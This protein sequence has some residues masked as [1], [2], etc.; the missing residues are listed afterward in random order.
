MGVLILQDKYSTDVLAKL[1]TQ[2]YFDAAIA[3]SR[4][5][6]SRRVNDDGDLLRTKAGRWSDV[7][8]NK[9]GRSTAGRDRLRHMKCRREAGFGDSGRVGLVCGQAIVFRLQ[10]FARF[11]PFRIERDARNRAHLLAL[12]LSEMTDAFRAFV[13][14]DLVELRAHRD[15]VVRA[16]GLAHVAI[17][18]VVG[19]Q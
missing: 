16:L 10:L 11:A 8:W 18:A 12:G 6:V 1:E 9:A 14:I 3:Q 17:D 19:N 2:N 5:R 13:R 15:R 7:F 4:T